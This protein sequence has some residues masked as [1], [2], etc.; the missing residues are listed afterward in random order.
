MASDRRDP[1]DILRAN[2]HRR[3]PIRAWSLIV[4]IFGDVV[5]PRGGEIGMQPLT[6]VLEAAGL[7]SG[8]V[9]TAMSRLASD[10]W[11]ERVRSGRLSFYRLSE[12]GRREV[13]AASSR[14][15]GPRSGAN[16]KMAPTLSLVIL[17]P[18]AAPEAARAWVTAAGYAAL[19]PTV[20][21]KRAGGRPESLPPGFIELDATVAR[22]HENV[23][24]A[25]L[26]REALD[27]LAQS[28]DHVTR[29]AH[30]V[31]SR[32]P[33]DGLAALT[34]RVLLIHEYR[35]TALR[36][37]GLPLGL[38]PEEGP[39][40]R[41]RAAVAAAYASL[42]QPSETW[43]DAHGTGRHGP[44]PKPDRPLALRFMQP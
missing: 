19:S 16:A 22:G 21:W 7:T 6:K 5:A 39:A 33:R 15:Y 24:A 35:R 41:C 11:V 8:V 31:E 2:F 27:S 12:F 4:T 13:E 36:D 3:T 26:G 40:M 9:R 37:P 25:L 29:L 43:L 34:A 17:A 28:Y 32:P 42:L 44:M 20:F 18:V 14:I 10:G 38:M 23:A 30:A 1:L